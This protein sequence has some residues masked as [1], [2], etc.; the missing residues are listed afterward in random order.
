MIRALALAVLVA[1]SPL[2][3]VIACA[4]SLED[5]WPVLFRQT[6]VG[7]SGVVFTL[8]KFRSMRLG[9]KGSQITQQG[10]RRI[11][12]VGRFIR[13]YKLD[14]IPQLWNVVRGD[15][16]FIGARPEVPCFVDRS[17]PLWQHTL[18]RMPGITSLA[19]ILYR[20]EEQLLSKAVEPERY[21]REVVLPDK[22]RLDLAY[23]NRRSLRS[24]AYVLWL[25]F[26]F[27]VV[28]SAYDPQKVR[29]RLVPEECTR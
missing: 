22:L 4:I 23:S 28:P 5:G 9:E 3:L 24:D 19:T 8:L 11:T 13:R 27:S 15:I 26:I 17:D 1:T 14:E 12:R 2:L 25:T 16:G 29:G 7:R 21:Y 10:D 6:R 18:A 20:N